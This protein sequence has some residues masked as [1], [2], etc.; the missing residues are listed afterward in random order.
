MSQDT[1]NFE[2]LRRLLALKRYEQP[3]PGYYHSFSREVIVRIKAGERG[4]DA[5]GYV[6]QMGWLQRIWAAFEA[7]PAFAGA[8]GLALCSLVVFGVVSADNA[9]LN[10]Q[11]VTGEPTPEMQSTGLRVASSDTSGSS[12]AASADSTDKSP[13]HA[14]LASMG[15]QPSLFDL[16]PKVQSDQAGLHLNLA[17]PQ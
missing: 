8:L 15:G 14:T 1:E 3:P 13:I 6:W 17:T 16:V 11:A 7:R 10:I 4:E 12:L 9:P 2:S 5:Y